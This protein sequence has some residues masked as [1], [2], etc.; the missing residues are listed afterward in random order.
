MST[1]PTVLIT[2]PK[3]VAITPMQAAGSAVTTIGSTSLPKIRPAP[4]NPMSCTES[5][6]DATDISTAE[7]SAPKGKK[8]RL[9]HL[10]WE[11]KVQR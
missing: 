10:T 2:V 8:R 11:E 6:N 3:F 9:D 7:A 4:P 5:S 1:Q